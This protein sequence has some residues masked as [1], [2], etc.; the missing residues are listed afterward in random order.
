MLSKRCVSTTHHGVLIYT[1]QKHILSCV[2]LR[3]SFPFFCWIAIVIFKG[4]QGLW[5]TCDVWQ[6]IH[7]I[8]LHTL[9]FVL[10]YVLSWCE[11][12][13]A[14]RAGSKYTHIVEQNIKI[15]FLMQD[16][17]SMVAPIKLIF[18]R[19]TKWG[20]KHFPM[21]QFCHIMICCHGNRNKGFWF[22]KII[23]FANNSRYSKSE[24]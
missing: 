15:L 5:I 3:G 8:I 14:I 9:K 12:A 10:A 1:P 17:D 7:F 18:C 2:I 6:T 16:F 19:H 23:Y 4:F 11:S 20:A 13:E 22:F 24:S 21:I